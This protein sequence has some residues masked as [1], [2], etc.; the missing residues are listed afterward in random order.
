MKV[1]LVNGSPKEEGC[2]F[3]A[4]SEVARALEYEGIEAH[5]LQVGHMDLPGCKACLYCRKNGCCVYDDA[6][7][8]F[9]ELAKEADGFVFGTPVHFAAPSAA[10]TAFMDRVFYS[11]MVGSKSP[12]YL[13]PAAAVVVARRAGTTAALDQMN[14][15][16]ALGQMPV[17]TGQY[18]NL[19]HGARPEEMEQDEE[20]MLTMR[21]LGRNM[22][23]FLK[24]KQAGIEAGV[25]F[26]YEEA[27]KRTNFLRREK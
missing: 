19:T 25:P 11:N 7:N 20:G 14:K 4:L 9:S 13:K 22:A 1:L 16:F 15:Y 18:W 8:L 3:T 17:L 24:I 21:T 6:V 2:T 23:W 26:P 27:P 10:M 12:F 5:I